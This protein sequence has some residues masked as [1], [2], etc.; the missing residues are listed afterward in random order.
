V[1]LDANLAIASL[2]DFAH[3]GPQVR[4]PISAHKPPDPKENYE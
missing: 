2:D 4:R 1:H 3:S